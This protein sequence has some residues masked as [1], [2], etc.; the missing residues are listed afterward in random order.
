MTDQSAWLGFPIAAG[1]AFTIIIL[2]WNVRRARK[3]SGPWI[4]QC[5]QQTQS[6]YEVNVSFFDQTWNPT[7]GQG[8]R[9]WIGPGTPIVGPGYAIYWLDDSDHVH[10][11]FQSR[12][13]GE[14]RFNGPFPTFPK[15]PSIWHSLHGLARWVL[16][17]DGALVIGGAVTGYLLSSG[18]VL[19]RIA[20]ACVGLGIGWLATSVVSVI[21]MVTT[22]IRPASASGPME[23]SGDDEAP[24]G[25]ER[26]IWKRVEQNERIARRYLD[27]HRGHAPPR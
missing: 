4:A 1:I 20:G 23:Q 8:Q 3:F 9:R 17:V 22:S 12:D 7:P 6:P 10:L 15:R 27:E 19:T 2:V 5:L 11:S 26:D 18:S 25:S 21:Y 16:A 13:G 24:D 14:R